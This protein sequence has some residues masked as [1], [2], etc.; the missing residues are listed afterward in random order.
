LVTLKTELQAT[1]KSLDVM[2]KEGLP[3]SIGSKAEADALERGL[4]DALEQVR[5]AKKKL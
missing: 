3:G 5:A 1:L 4:T 2:A